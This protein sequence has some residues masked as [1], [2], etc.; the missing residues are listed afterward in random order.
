MPEHKGW[1]LKANSDLKSAKKLFTGDDDT[2]DTAAY[3]TQQC[4]EKA[5]KAF[6]VFNNKVPPRTHDLEKLLELCVAFDAPLKVFA[7]EVITLIPYAI[8]SRYPDDY[9]EIKRIDVEVAIAIARKIL[10]VIVSK[11]KNNDDLTLTIFE[12]RDE[13]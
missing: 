9:F 13:K 1:L 5:L 3:H 6:L 11:T 2:L 10:T 8:Y 12:I 4:V 7:D